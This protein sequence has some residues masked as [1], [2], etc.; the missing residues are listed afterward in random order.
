MH[1]LLLRLHAVKCL[2]RFFSRFNQLFPPACPNTRCLFAL[3][4]H[5]RFQ[6]PKLRLSF[7]HHHFP[8]LQFEGYRQFL[9]P[10]RSRLLLQCH[11]SRLGL[12]C[13]RPALLQ[14]ALRAPQLFSC[15]RHLTLQSS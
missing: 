9:L 2:E 8:I 7:R 5:T 11:H 1:L 13:L 10:L 6:L 15:L 12:L 4:F 3:H 14:Q